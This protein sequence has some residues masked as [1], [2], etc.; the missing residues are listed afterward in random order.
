MKTSNF[1]PFLSA[2]AQAEYLTYYDRR[3]QTWPVESTTTMVDTFLGQTFVRLSG[4]VDA[5]PLALLPGSVFSSLMWTPN[6]KALSTHFRTYAVDNI[7]DSGRSIFTRAPKSPADFVQWLD[8]LF[9]GLA[10]GNQINLMGLSYGSWLT[11]QYALR[12]PQRLAKI[13]MLASPA[14]ASMNPGFIFRFLFCLV[15]PGYL[16]KFGYWLFAD[17]AQQGEASRRLI[18]EVID[19]MRLGGRCFKPRAVITPKTLTDHELHDLKVPALFLCGEHEK[20]FSPHKASQRLNQIAPHLQTEIIANAGHD[21]SFAQAEL[22][23]KKA[24]E[25]LRG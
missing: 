21:L 17:T 25:F 16:T 1:H 5:P 3:A 24:L 20:T 14:I 11:H 4:P 9:T 13:V 23:S 18:D 7:Y 15:S 6:I 2:Q 10:L 19:E 8:E 12:F 22:V